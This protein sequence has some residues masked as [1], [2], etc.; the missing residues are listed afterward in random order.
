MIQ[1]FSFS[2][3]PSMP[4]QL[5][6][7][8]RYPVKGFSAQELPKTAIKPNAPLAWDRAFAIENGPSGFEPTNPAH[9]SK[10]AFLVLMKQPEL[11]RLRTEFDPASGIMTISENGEIKAKG[12][13]LAHQN[14]IE[15]E[16][17][18]ANYCDKPLRGSPKILH[19]PGHAFTDS[20]TQ[21][22]TLI[23]LASIR[24][25]EEKIGS[26]LDPLRFRANLYFDCEQAWLEHDWVGKSLKIGNVTFRVRKR[27]QRCAATNANLKTGERDQMIPKVL[28]QHFDHS[29]MG[30]HIVAEQAGSISVGDRIQPE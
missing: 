17:F 7:I 11:A 24:A 25:L 20:R 23:N 8:Y 4:H 26:Q 28:L 10:N 13:L 2:G 27:T 21:D 6:A 1:F 22:L 18:L 16:A 14:Q 12:N 3:F 15:L 5:T 19:S 30:I 29:D 9:I